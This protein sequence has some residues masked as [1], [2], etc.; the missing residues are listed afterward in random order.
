MAA[1]YSKSSQARQWTFTTEGLKKR[2]DDLRQKNEH[3]YVKYEVADQRHIN[4]FL[5]QRES[6]HQSIQSDLNN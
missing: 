2:Q 6:L 1:D 5:Q 4:I 3:I